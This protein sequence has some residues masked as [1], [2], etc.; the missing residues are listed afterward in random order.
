MLRKSILALLAA[1]VVAS[2]AFAQKRTLKHDGVSRKATPIAQ[3]A[4]AERDKRIAVPVM[5]K[6]NRTIFQM[7]D[8]SALTAARKAASPRH[9]LGDGTTIYGSIIYSENPAINRVGVYSFQAQNNPD[10]NL[11]YALPSSYEVNGGG[12]YINGKYYYFSYT[13]F[14]EGGYY[15]FMYFKSFDP[16][17]GESETIAAHN[18]FTDGFDET[19][20][21]HDLTY[22]PT[23]GNIYAV[24]YIIV[25]D[26]TGLIQRVRPA[27]SI[28]DL[29]TGFVTPIAQ[30]PQ[31]IAIAANTSGELYGITKG[32]D[33]AL[34][35]INKESGECTEIGPTGL[36]PEYVQ[37]ATFD[38]VTD[39][40]YWAEAQLI[41]QSGLY[42]MNLSTGAA[43]LVTYFPGNEEF[44]GIYIPVPEI[45]AAAPAAVANQKAVFNNGSHSGTVSFTAPTSTYGGAALSGSL[46]AVVNVDGTDR[47]PVTVTPGQTVSVDLTLDEGIH[48]FS[49]QV[50]NVAGAGP[51]TGY[52]WYVGIDGPAKVQNLKVANNTNGM[53]QISWNA[54]SVGRHGGYID[55]AKLTYDVV[56][57]PDNVKVATGI[58]A[59]NCIDRTN[60]AVDNVY[61]VVTAYCD[62]RPGIETA[63][64]TGLFGSGYALPVTFDFNDRSQFDLCTVVD[65][66]N[67]AEYQYHWGYWMY[68]D[69][70][71]YADVETPCVMYAYSPEAPA[72][73]YLFI[74][75]FIAQEG[76]KYRVTFTMWTRGNKERLEIT[77]SSSTDIN[78]QTVILPVKEYNHTTPTEFTVEFNALQTGNCYIGFH[79][80]SATKMWYLFVDDVTV[81]EVPEER[82]PAA[83]E[84]LTVT[85]GEHGA[86]TAT[87]SF[88]APSLTA[89]GSSLSSLTAINVYRGNDPTVIYTFPAPAPGASLSWTDEHPLRGFNTYRV[90]AANAYGEGEKALATQ[91]VGY[92]FPT[93]VT[94][95]RLS[96]ESGYPVLTW[97]APTTGMNGG[98][99]NPAELTYR[100]TRSDNVV[101]SRSFSGT[102]F[103]DR[104]LSPEVQ[105]F[106]Y[107]QIEPISEAGVGDYALSDYIIYGNPYTGDFWE[108]FSDTYL[109]TDPWVTHVVKGENQLWTTQSAGYSPY[110]SAAD[111]DDGLMA[112]LSTY[113]RSGDEGRL[114][115][116][117]I[118]IS[119][120]NVPIFSFAFFHNPDYDTMMGGDPFQDRMIP[121]LML[122]DG[123]IVALDEPIYV[124]DPTYMAEWVL[125]R[126]DLSDYKK[127]PYVKLCFHGIASYDNDIYIDMVSV[128]DNSQYDLAG[129]S[130]SAPTSVK[131]GKTGYYRTTILN[132]GMYKAENYKVVLYRDGQ[133]FMSESPMYPLAS[134]SMAT[135]EFPVTYTLDD[136]GKTY[137]Y[138]VYIDYQQD[139]VPG[140]NRSQGIS[141]TVESPD[142]PE[143]QYVEANLIGVNDVD[144][145]W[146]NAD[147]LH[148]EDDF[149]S[150]TAFSIDNIGDYTLVDGDG[151]NTYTFGGLYFDN[152][153]APKAFIVFNPVVLGIT[154]ILEEYI[155]HSGNQM[156]AAFASWGYDTSGNIVSIDNDDWLIS[157]RV[158]GGTEVSFWAKAILDYISEPEQFEVMYS[159]TDTSVSSFKTLSGV[160]ESEYD[161]VHYTYTLPDNAKYFAIHRVGNDSFLLFVDD[162]SFVSVCD[163]EGVSLTGYRIYRNNEVI[164]EVTADS[165]HFTDYGLVEGRYTYGVSALF[166]ERESRRVTK[167]VHVGDSDIESPTVSCV[168]I[169]AETGSIFIEGAEG[170][171]V[172]VSTPA[173]INVFADNT[174]SDYRV[175]V[176]SGV[177][178]VRAGDTVCKL[179]VR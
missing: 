21:V 123:S 163:I 169:Y 48:S 28:V 109:S 53:P 81:D 149:E 178:I 34:Y 102:E 20:V 18:N 37:S 104:T 25:T 62:G 119:S 67:D 26:D 138:Y 135:F 173:G 125:Y 13:Y 47:S 4:P 143:P 137:N 126:Y 160:M 56:R 164:G 113:G 170:L 86:L 83:V 77:A 50:S 99:I 61:Y 161:W 174:S 116:P 80:L 58:T 51:R 17:T 176:V 70:N 78:S 140:N 105:S 88:N 106:L 129:Y 98:Y 33:S 10:I 133:P 114:V 29:I 38:P 24:S 1:A 91:Y 63:S 167:A 69:D 165:R 52:S 157:P 44:T 68:S 111:G 141:T 41:G 156:L 5:P 11:E 148:Q 145:T 172:T 107:Y 15:T 45:A 36:N 59:T 85:P 75:P 55:P 131:V 60:F 112:F 30:T 118:D 73:D 117:K 177:Y 162:L 103:V 84:N 134:G 136:E 152:D 7:H 94:N 100:I 110:C 124:D 54:P 14:E 19:Q 144:L 12:V 108:S 166:G 27:V 32:A 46:S 90:V 57:M 93:R 92:D 71:S 49:V 3:S 96:D 150:Y 122:P 89:A 171:D 132:Q 35:R 97:D 139:E 74:P 153:D 147:A 43:E 76:K 6:S 146:G 168:N 42:E 115:S 128:E 142:V 39:K 16:A 65:A 9:V 130:F 23:T 66:G 158:H 40:L 87:I 155:P 95:V 22:D 151:G 101:M 2:G 8:A 79:C 31:F 127:Y 159:T 154:S 64:E 72:D 120:M 175:N 121:E 82:A 179:V